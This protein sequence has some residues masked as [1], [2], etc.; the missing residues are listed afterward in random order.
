MPSS[1]PYILFEGPLSQALTETLW[2][3]YLRSLPN[4]KWHQL[5]PT[6]IA[7]G[8]L[9]R[10]Y[11]A[12]HIA[13]VAKRYGWSFEILCEAPKMRFYVFSALLIGAMC[14]LKLVQIQHAFAGQAFS[15]ASFEAQAAIFRYFHPPIV[16]SLLFKWSAHH[17]LRTENIAFREDLHFLYNNNIELSTDIPTA[18]LR[19]F[20]KYFVF[21]ALGRSAIFPIYLKNSTSQ[22]WVVLERVVQNQQT[23]VL[24]RAID[25]GHYE[26]QGYHLFFQ[27]TVPHPSPDF[28]RKIYEKIA[29]ILEKTPKFSLTLNGYRIGAFAAA[30]F[31]MHWIQTTKNTLMPLT[32]HLWNPHGITAEENK[33]FL[34]IAKRTIYPVDIH[35]HQDHET[36][37]ST[38]EII[39]AGAGQESG[40]V[41]RHL[42]QY[43]EEARPF[44]PYCQLDIPTSHHPVYRYSTDWTDPKAIAL[45]YG[46]RSFDRVLYGIF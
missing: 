40:M 1:V 26:N 18:N 27:S 21:S 9:I 46:S 3:T 37:A 29:P 42:H 38:P 30:H 44:L 31:A 6:P 25:N 43:Q 36:H 12:A 19:H 35:I 8:L 24:L 2:P 7:M 33:N 5:L 39:I 11:S 28:F 4:F 34:E 41:H 20:S 45:A 32:L 17:P 13:E 10:R 14:Q 16:R 15:R 22:Y 23:A